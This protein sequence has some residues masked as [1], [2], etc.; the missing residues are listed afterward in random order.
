MRNWRDPP[1]S[2]HVDTPKLKAFMLSGDK[3][4]EQ[5]EGHLIYCSQCMDVMVE[6]TM[7]ELK[8]T[9]PFDK[10]PSY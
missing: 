10:P 1:R 5:E 6:A 2:P 3:L 7:T 4:T 8:R 9:S